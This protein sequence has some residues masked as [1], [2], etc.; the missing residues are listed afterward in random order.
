MGD[1]VNIPVD[2]KESESKQMNQQTN[3]HLSAIGNANWNRE[4]ID[5]V[6]KLSYIMVKV[7]AM[8]HTRFTRPNSSCGLKLKFVLVELICGINWH[9]VYTVNDTIKT[10]RMSAAKDATALISHLVT[11]LFR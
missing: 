3:K 10:A 8:I 4:L 7:T 11:I 2:D 5:P 1:L 6:N 9:P